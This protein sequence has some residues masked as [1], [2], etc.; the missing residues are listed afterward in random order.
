MTD[1]QHNF[2]QRPLSDSSPDEKLRQAGEMLMPSANKNPRWFKA[3][4]CKG[5]RSDLV[6]AQS[7]KG[8]GEEVRAIRH[9]GSDAWRTLPTQQP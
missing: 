9:A 3:F 7:G 1:H 6:R 4:H 2:A 8:K 5:C